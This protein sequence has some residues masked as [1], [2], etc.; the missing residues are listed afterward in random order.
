M[1]ESLWWFRRKDDGELTP[2]AQYIIDAYVR[3]CSR[4]RKLPKNFSDDLS[5][6]LDELSR[7]H[8]ISPR[9]KKYWDLPNYARAHKLKRGAFLK[10]F[11]EMETIARTRFPDHVPNHRKAVSL[12]DEKKQEIRDRFLVVQDFQKV[13]EEFGIEPFRV[14]QLCRYEKAKIVAEREATREQTERELKAQP[15]EPYEPY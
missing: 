7:A 3:Q 9:R 5:L 1:P 6:W 8:Q 10:R 11:R 14:G 2:E 15:D 13:A 4:G 12:T